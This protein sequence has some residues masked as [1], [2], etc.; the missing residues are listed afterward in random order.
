[1]KVKTYERKG[2]VGGRKGTIVNKP[3]QTKWFEDDIDETMGTG[4]PD[5]A[6]KSGV[7]IRGTGAATKGLYA[8]GPLA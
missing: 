3:F 1:M 5:K 7:K 2:K 6:K 8:R 4:Y